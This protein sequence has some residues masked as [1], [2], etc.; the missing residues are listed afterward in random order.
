MAWNQANERVVPNAETMNI[1]AARALAEQ[2]EQQKQKEQEEKD[3]KELA[4]KEMNEQFRR[5]EQ[6]IYDRH[7]GKTLFDKICQDIETSEEIRQKIAQAIE[8]P[9][10]NK[11]GKVDLIYADPG[12]IF[13]SGRFHTGIPIKYEKY[14]SPNGGFYE[15]GHSSYAKSFSHEKLQSYPIQHEECRGW[16]VAVTYS[17]NPYAFLSRHYTISIQKIKKGWFS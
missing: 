3:K 4:E 11:D 2:K 1:L 14:E 6:E 8:D 12:F 10:Q 7:I 9:R 16:E 5:H 17:T 13:V 15:Y